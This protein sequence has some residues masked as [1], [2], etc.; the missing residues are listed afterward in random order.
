M[1]LG[2]QLDHP[3]KYHPSKLQSNPTLPWL[4]GFILNSQSFST[5]ASSEIM[6]NMCLNGM[7]TSSSRIV[8]PRVGEANS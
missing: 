3:D 4:L 1:T 2:D 6:L 5:L 7:V 8:M